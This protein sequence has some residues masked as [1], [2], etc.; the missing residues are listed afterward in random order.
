MEWFKRFWADHGDRLT[1]MGLATTGSIAMMG[2]GNDKLV[3][4]GEV[5]L[6]GVV[7]LLYNYARSTKKDIDK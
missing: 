5:V 6:I 2:S 4:A 1:F 3:S 7:M